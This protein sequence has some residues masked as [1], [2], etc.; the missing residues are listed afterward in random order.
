MSLHSPLSG[1]V[2]SRFGGSGRSRSKVAAALALVVSIPFIVSTFAA[3]VTVGSGTLAFGQGSQQAVACD[4]QVYVA[5]GQEWKSAPTPSDPTAGFFRVKSVTV[6]GVDLVACQRTKLRIRLINMQGQEIVLGT[7]NATVLQMAIP[8]T[9]SPQSS[10]DPVALSLG[11]LT[12][13]GDLISGLMHAA[14]NLSTSG[15]SVYDGSNL[16]PNSADVTF[17][18]D[19]TQQHINIDGAVVGRT[20]VESVNNPSAMAG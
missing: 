5:L 6:S 13:S 15:T 16:S 3:S 4:P 14:I 8:N 2:R 1:S 19:P 17:Y 7:S 18:I 20:T 12:G 9:S 11:Y 10:S